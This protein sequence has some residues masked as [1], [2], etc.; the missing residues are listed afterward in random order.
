MNKI[1]ILALVLLV[2]ACINDNVDDCTD[3]SCT[4]E[5]PKSIQKTSV[6]GNGILE[7]PE[8][9]DVGNPCGSGY[10]KRCRCENI[11]EEEMID[12]RPCWVVRLQANQANVAYHTRIMWVDQERYVPVKE[13]LYAKSGKLLKKTQLMDFKQTDNRWFPWH[14]RFKDVLKTGKGTELVVES[15]EFDVPIPKHLFSKAALR[16]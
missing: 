1:I 6:C 3:D 15:I 5:M 14:I 10:C 8:E 2:G 16:R 11:T 7:A 13:E 4:V 9:C 12:N